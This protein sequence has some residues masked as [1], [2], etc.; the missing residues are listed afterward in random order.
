MPSFYKTVDPDRE[1]REAQKR[2]AAATEPKGAAEVA[3]QPITESTQPAPKSGNAY[4]PKTRFVDGKVQPA[5]PNGMFP[6][7]K[8]DPSLSHADRVERDKAKGV[9]SPSR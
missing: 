5:D 1:A 9:D 7:P 6:D 3:S 4:P 2:A 8:T